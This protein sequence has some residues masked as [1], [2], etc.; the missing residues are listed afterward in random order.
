MTRVKS[1][2]IIQEDLRKKLS[3]KPLPEIAPRISIDI[4][5]PQDDILNLHGKIV[6]ELRRMGYDVA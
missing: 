1:K 5:G 4:E 2:F 3:Q 6:V